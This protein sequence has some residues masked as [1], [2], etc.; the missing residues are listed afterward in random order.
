ML[1]IH[2]PDEARTY[3]IYFLWEARDIAFPVDGFPG[4]AMICSSIW[5]HSVYHHVRN[6]V[7]ILEEGNHPLPCCPKCDMFLTCRALNG[8]NPA[9]EMCVRGEERIHK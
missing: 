9:T 3:R 4:R 8:R 5:V 2:I 1:P 6:K 7:V